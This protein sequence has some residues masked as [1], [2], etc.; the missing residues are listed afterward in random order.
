MKKLFGLFILLIANIFPQNNIDLLVPPQGFGIQSLNSSGNSS[1]VNGTFN[2]LAMNPAAI[3]TLE[4][5]SFGISYQISSDIETGWI[6]D[7]KVFRQIDL[8]PQSSGAV[9]SWTNF[10]FGLGFTQSYNSRVDFIWNPHS[11]EDPEI[12]E[13]KGRV[14]SYS[15]SAAYSINDIHK[16]S[17]LSFG[18]K[19]TF[20]SVN[21]VSQGS[22]DEVSLSDYAS[23]YAFG[24]LYSNKSTSGRI[25]KIGLSFT[26]NTKFEEEYSVSSMTVI[27]ID[28]SNRIQDIKQNTVSGNIPAKLNLDLSFDISDNFNLNGSLAG[29]FWSKNNNQLKDQTEISAG[30][31]YYLNEIISPSLGFYLTDRKYEP[32]FYNFNNKFN[33]LCFI[34]GTRV[35]FNKISLDIALADS[36]LF[37]D[38]FSRQTIGKLGLGVML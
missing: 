21:F 28:N 36:H 19:Y 26:T 18:I 3:A 15:A 11:F 20:N 25:S 6:N 10:S 24:I 30:V 29:I 5:Y 14:N 27:I 17:D 1:I 4:N 23:S 35:S 16:G 38:E 32:D 33:T 37:S 2:I 9:V 34:A 8:V 22:W 12:T 13:F 31:T 7:S